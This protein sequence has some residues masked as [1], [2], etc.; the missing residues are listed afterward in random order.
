ML[1]S[2]TGLL[3]VLVKVDKVVLESLVLLPLVVLVVMDRVW[4]TTFDEDFSHKYMMVQ[5]LFSKIER[6]V[7]RNCLAI[8]MYQ[9]FLHH[10]I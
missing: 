4:C 8:H 5:T 9:H 10:N 6:V 3:M 7:I 1:I 2:Q